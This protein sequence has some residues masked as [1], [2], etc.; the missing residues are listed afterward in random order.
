MFCG[1]GQEFRELREAQL[2]LVE[3]A[4]SLKHLSLH[5]GVT[6][7][8]TPRCSEI[9]QR[10]PQQRIGIL[11]WVIGGLRRV[12]RPGPLFGLV[13]VNAI[14][15]A[16]AAAPASLALTRVTR[17]CGAPPAPSHGPDL[18]LA[19]LQLLQLHEP[20][21]RS[22]RKEL[23]ELAEA[24][25]GL[26]EVRIQLLHDLLQPI[27]AH[28]VA[29]RH[30]FFQRLADK[31]PGVP[32]LLVEFGRLGET[33]E[34]RVGVI[35]VAVLNEDVRARFLNAHADDVLPV[36]LELEHQ[37]GKIRI[38]RE[39]DIRPDL[40]SNEDE[41]DRVDRHANVG[42]VLLVAPVRGREDQIDRRLRER[43]DVLRIAT[44]VGIGSLD[45]DLALDDIGVEKAFEFLRE[46]AAHTHRDVVEVDEQRC[47]RR[48][49]RRGA[50]SPL[51]G[52][53]GIRCTHLILSRKLNCLAARPPHP[54][55]VVG[56]RAESGKPAGDAHRGRRDPVR[57]IRSPTEPRGRARP[58]APYPYPF[59][60]VRPGNEPDQGPCPPRGSRGTSPRSRDL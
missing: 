41:L 22:L 5:V 20:A 8:L 40:G 25:A 33:G 19:V 9:L 47:V 27:R 48:V 11:E 42:R 18:V 50:R 23:A 14:T 35:L 32:S 24:H 43:H 55:R 54:T 52:G 34:A 38:P 13:A 16:S 39:Q 44:P 31:H 21:R 56:S 12:R 57:P 45:A 58:A 30:H 6:N 46:V 28:D 4:V 36:L 7:G 3:R 15:S 10:G 49:L 60:V 29:S 37:A 53:P 26:V 1:L 17:G 2:G 59:A 51:V